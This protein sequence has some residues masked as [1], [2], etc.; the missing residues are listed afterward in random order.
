MSANIFSRIEQNGLA[1]PLNEFWLADDKV[2]SSDSVIVRFLRLCN[3]KNSSNWIAL[4]KRMQNPTSQVL[5]V[6]LHVFCDALFALTHFFFLQRD[7]G[8]FAELV[9]GDADLLKS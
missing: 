2:L 7:L 3:Q 5:G 4:F 8:R 1:S 6:P 9:F